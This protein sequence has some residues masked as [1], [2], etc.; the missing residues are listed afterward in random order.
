MSLKMP[1]KKIAVLVSG[2]G[3]NLQALID[4]VHGKEADIVLVISNKADAG[5][6]KRAKDANIDNIYVNPEEYESNDRYDE[7]LL[8]QLKKYQVD[9]VVLAGYLKI[10]TGT[11]IKA[12]PNAIIN[13]HPA[14]IPSF[15]GKGYYGM[16]VHQKVRES[17][18]KITG[19][20]VHFV[21]EIAD[22]G[23]IIAQDTVLI[24][25]DDTPESIQKKVLVLE[26]QLLPR[27]VADFCQDKLVVDERIVR[28]I[29]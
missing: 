22:D 3:S 28:K 1:L 7:K 10:V 23:P 6:L 27:V 24:S 15:S 12:F 20:T 18:V 16:N 14:L 5:G 25:D 17:G 26:H 2:G 29:L 19:A 8:E 11:F 13:I 21:N 4:K 9:L